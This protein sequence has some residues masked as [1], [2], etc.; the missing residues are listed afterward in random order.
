MFKLLNIFSSQCKGK[1]RNKESYAVTN[2]NRELG[3]ALY[4]CQKAL[5]IE[6]EERNR[7]EKAITERSQYISKSLEQLHSRKGAGPPPAAVKAL[8][9]KKKLE[10]QLERVE[11]RITTLVNQQMTLETAQMNCLAESSLS[12]GMST[13]DSFHSAQ[14]VSVHMVNE[15]LDKI[16]IQ[17]KQS[18]EFSTSLSRKLDSGIYDEDELLYEL[19]QMDIDGTTAL[20]PAFLPDAPTST[21]MARQTT[22]RSNEFDNVSRVE[23]L[24]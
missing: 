10:G 15:T 24:F 6:E 13:V 19:D 12:V 2:E 7:L 20:E 18:N 14:D 16:Q 3:A 5:R 17:G 23:I 9:K 4:Q 21:P 1:P 11:Y 8:S 22:K